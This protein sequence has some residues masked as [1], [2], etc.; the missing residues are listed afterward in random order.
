[1]DPLLA[2]A[3]FVVGLILGSFLNVCISRIPRHRSIVTPGSHCHS[4]GAPI[5]WRD[6]IP[7]LSWFLLRGRCRSCGRSISWRYPAV[8]LLTAILFVA[9]LAS[10]GVSVLLLRACALCFLLTGLIF[11][12][13]ET[14]LLPAEFTYPGILLGLMFAWFAPWDPSGARFLLS[15]FG[16]QSTTSPAALSLL[17]A[18]FAMIITAGFFFLAWAMYYLVRK[19]DGLGF[20]DIALMAMIAAFLGL[21]LSLV[22]LVLSPI[23]ATLYAV[24]FLIRR[25]GSE[26]HPTENS[27]QFLSQSIPFGVFLGA[28]ALIALFAGEWIW[29][30]YLGLFA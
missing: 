6:N 17:D 21:K 28:C 8:E 7:L 22:V 4:C 13:A 9:C 5:A 10:F 27:G 15:S 18:I 2:I 23:L 1:M 16:A 29:R 19:R 26:P 24:T 25:K 3:L 11:M 12:D 14:G 30:W 20:G